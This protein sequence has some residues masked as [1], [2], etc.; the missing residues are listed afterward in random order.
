MQAKPSRVVRPAVGRSLAFCGAPR[1]RLGQPR[2]ETPP[3][4]ADYR[5]FFALRRVFL[6]LRRE[7]FPGCCAAASWRRFLEAQPGLLTWRPRPI[8]KPSSGTFS[9]MVEPAAT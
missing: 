3:A 2:C 5:R 9:V 7:D 8:P 4:R 6:L 1:I